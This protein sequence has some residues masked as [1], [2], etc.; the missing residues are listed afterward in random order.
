M[1]VVVDR[2]SLP[3]GE[4]PGSGPGDNPASACTGRTLRFR[5][6]RRRM[7]SHAAGTTNIDS[8]GAVIMPPTIGAAMRCMTSD[9]VPAPT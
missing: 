2:V 3:A 4:L 6:P 7:S 8:S 5:K 1:P 9:P